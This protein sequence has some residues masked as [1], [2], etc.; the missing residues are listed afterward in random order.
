[1]EKMFLKNISFDTH[2]TANLPLLPISRKFKFIFRKTSIY[3]EKGPI[4]V[5]FE[6]SY[7]FN[8]I[9]RW[10]CNNL[11]ISKMAFR[12]VIF[13]IILQDTWTFSIGKNI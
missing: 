8:R 1:M 2:S 6:K 9:L 3:S 5:R 13:V 4:F 10:I 11:V 7:D 12:I